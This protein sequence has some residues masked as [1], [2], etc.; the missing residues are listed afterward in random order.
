MSALR[1]AGIMCAFGAGGALVS[2]DSVIV[3]V[4]LPFIS[5]DLSTTTSQYSWVASSY[6]LAAASLMPLW[7]PMSDAVGRKPVLTAGLLVFL[8][9]SLISA[10]ARDS[11]TLI[12]G[13]AVQGMGEGAFTVMTNICMADLF[14]LHER[15]LYIAIYAG[16]SC[17]GAALAPI[18]GGVLTQYAGW[19]WCFWINL[20]VTAACIA[21]IVGLLPFPMLKLS[22]LTELKRV[23]WLGMLLVSCG[24]VLLLFGLQFGGI[25]FA[26]RSAVVIGLVTAG[27]GTLI[28]FVFQ[29]TKSL[30]PIAPLRLFRHRS[31]SACLLVCFSH[32]FV[33]I[34]CLY[35]LPIYFQLVLQA[36]AVDAGLWLLI[37]AIPTTVFTI[38][39]ALVIQST[40]R[41][42]DTIRAATAFLTL[43]TALSI[44]FPAYRSWVRIVISQLLLA[45][46]IGP[47]FQAP[48]IGLQ[49]A[50]RPSEVSSAYAT[51]IFLR[52]ISSA[53]SI[54]I[55]Q[56]ALQ[57]EL[58]KQTTALLDAGV[59]PDIVAS[60]PHTLDVFWASVGL[61]NSNRDALRGALTFALSRVWILYTIFAVFGFLGSYFIVDHKLKDGLPHQ[62]DG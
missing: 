40:G 57:N 30:Y 2:M 12:G 9:G 21:L 42:R 32:G 20:P 33:Y 37:T 48:L 46:G 53:I 44:T 43:G 11:N 61:P 16:A 39:A 17:V 49:A 54:V 23:D 10:L 5:K 38:A 14:R 50:V 13:R 27:A 41:Y 47:L 4:A 29:Q 36:G 58:Q 45:V 28:L 26:W 35:Y 15:S 34:A 7:G 1:K 55:G 8:V 6:L 51:F 52:T 18:L 60:L 59:S 31:G 62:E 3:S 25:V 22:A 24:T 56:V 19:R